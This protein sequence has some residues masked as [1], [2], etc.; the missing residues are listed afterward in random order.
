MMTLETERD[1]RGQRH[2]DTGDGER[3]HSDI[4]TVV[5]QFTHFG[6]INPL[7]CDNRI[8]HSR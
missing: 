5:T 6:N 2:D 8:L 3:L 7:C 1:L 4:G